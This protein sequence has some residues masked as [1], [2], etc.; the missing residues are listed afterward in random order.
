MKEWK[1]LHICNWSPGR[2][3]VRERHSLRIKGLKT[4]QNQWNTWIHGYGKKKRNSPLSIS[5]WNCRTLIK[6]LPWKQKKRKYFQGVILSRKR[7][8]CKH[9]FR[10][11]K[12]EMLTPLALKGLW[13]IYLREKKNSHVRKAW[14]ARR[15]GEKLTTDSGK[16]QKILLKIC[17]NFKGK[18]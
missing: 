7:K 6:K 14:A 9:I 16:F 1:V 2:K 10:Q 15:N 8:K 11:T 12:T 4:F 3:K 17:F 18:N 13:R 5:Q